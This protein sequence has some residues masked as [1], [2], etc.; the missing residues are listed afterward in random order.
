MSNFTIEYLK[1]IYTD[2]VELTAELEVINSKQTPYIYEM[3]MDEIIRL[4]NKTLEFCDEDLENFIRVMVEFDDYETVEEK[5]EYNLNDTWG[6][7]CNIKRVDDIEIVTNDFFIL[8]AQKNKVLF[9]S[10]R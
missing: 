3:V 10:A 8:I 5:I 4:Q 1:A 9:Y 7:C 6:G 2:I